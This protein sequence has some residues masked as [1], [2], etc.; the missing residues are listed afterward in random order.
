M[1]YQAINDEFR[2]VCQDLQLWS[3]FEGVPTKVGVTSIVVVE[4]ESAVMGMSN[5]SLI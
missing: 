1:F 2:H 5:A 3:F 4:R